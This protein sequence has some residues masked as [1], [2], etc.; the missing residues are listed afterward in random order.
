MEDKDAQ[1]RIQAIRASETLYKG[2]DKSLAADYKRLNT[3]SDTDVVMQSLMTMN[4]LKVADAAAALKQAQAANKAKGV[5]LV[6]SDGP[7]SRRDRQAAA[8]ASSWKRRRPSRPTSRQWSTR[9][10][11]STR[12]SASPATARTA[13]AAVC[14]DPRAL[15]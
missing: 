9:G 2:G 5:Q 6:A 11:R 10:G 15:R 12:R 3:D 8:A 4:T 14:R 1:I 13:T 7:Q